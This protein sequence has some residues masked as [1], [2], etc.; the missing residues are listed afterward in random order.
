MDQELVPHNQG[1]Q[2][3]SQDGEV[4][5]IVSM[6]EGKRDEAVADRRETES[7]WLRD[8]QQFEGNTIDRITKGAAD[9]GAAIKKANPVVHLTRTRTM[10]IAAR[11]INM[12]VP[13]NERSWDI[14]PTPVPSMAK[15]LEDDSEVI[16]PE[17]GQP[18]MVPDDQGPPP[19]QMQPP[20]PPMG[21]PGMDP[22]MQGGQP[23][24]DPSM[25]GMDPNMQGMDPSMNGMDPGMMPPDQGQPEQPPQRPLTKADIAKEELAEAERRATRMRDHMDD[26]LSECRYNAEQRK[27]IIDGCKIGTG[28]LEGP[29][30]AGSYKKIRQQMET[31]E[32]VTDIQDQPAPEFKAIDPWNFYPLPAERISE[33]EGVFIDKPM[34]RRQ[35]QELKLL[36]GF[37]ADIIDE[38]LREEPSHSS[39]YSASLVARAN[40]TGETQ[41]MKNRYSMWKYTGSLSRKDMERVGVDVDTELDVVDPI[42]EAW[43]CNG[44]LCKIKRHAL[45]GAYRLPYYVW[46]YEENE[47]SMFGYGVAYLMRDSDRVMQ[48]TWHMTLH[49]TALSAGP[50]LVR[51][52]GVIEPADGNENITGGL[53][54]WLLSDP[55]AT[56]NDAFALFQIDARTDGL[57]AV[58]DR[59][60]QNADEELGFPL[61][62]QGEPSEAVPTSSGLAMLLNASNVVQRRIAQSYDDEI[63]EP[64]ISAMYEY[65]M[66]YLEDNDAKGDMTIRPLGATKL[67]VKDMQT[68]HLMVIANMTT[69]DRFAPLM[70]DDELLRAILKAA[71]VDPDSMMKSE[72][73]L[74][75]QGPSE[76]E[77]AELEKIK[78]ETALLM[79]RANELQ[80]P[81][82]QP[83]GPDEGK[84]AEIQ[85]GYDKLQAEIQIQQMKLEQSALEA[86]GRSEVA[87]ADIEARFN[88]GAR[89]DETK[90]VIKE[91]EERR[92]AA[93]DGYLARLKAE[94]V[95]M[96][97]RNMERGFDTYG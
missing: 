1:L 35:M 92:K 34:T 74:S 89:A 63:I 42:V 76:A 11:I 90:R 53:K 87:M 96:K 7:R 26:Q 58:H 54:Q 10:S 71:D 37:E 4:T 65:N 48:S 75:Q 80:Q 16:D 91:L 13:S 41:P 33:C 6:L 51:M 18:Y 79:A 44:R 3:S 5:A 12:L 61:L 25:Q 59:A 30:V 22:N 85:L 32:W 52:A 56:V 39:T 38:I 83:G 24:M 29:T 15:D 46:N 17:T 60:R 66:I 31:G 20:G 9:Y 55:E 19:E 72:E 78:A 40:M 43:I 94:E 86:S 81:Q 70:K 84:M 69:N 8:L 62:A 77:M 97:K 93:T 50:Q 21:P 73:E 95:A 68:Q 14:E 67:V 88:L 28:I 2:M 57:M 27:V 64:S 47:T 49:N 23:G 36:P 45:E 82:Q